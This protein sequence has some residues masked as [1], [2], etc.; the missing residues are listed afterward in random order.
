MASRPQRKRPHSE[1][2]L[3]TSLLILF[4][5][6]W[7]ALAV[8]PV[9]RQDWMLENLLVVVALPVLIAT[10][11]RVRFSNASYIGLFLFLVLHSIGAHYTYSLVPYDAWWE[12]LTGATVRHISG[13]QRNHFDRFAHFFYGVV[14]LKPSIELFDR[15]AQPRGGWRLAMPLLFVMSHSAI[16]EIIEWIAAS[17]VAPE[18][19]NA[20][21]GTQG[22][23]WD[24]QKDMALATAGAVLSMVAIYTMR[25]M[26][27]RAL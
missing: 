22:D 26:R 17:L 13:P 18:L 14:A 12:A 1:W 6:T 8:A 3:S 11:H 2:F 10:R 9:N 20:Y 23:E 24:A 27:C 7:L 19:G 25:S 4:A 16:F 5:A 21:L 15:Y